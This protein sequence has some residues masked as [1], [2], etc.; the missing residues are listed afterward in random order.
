MC[1]HSVSELLL[2]CFDGDTDFFDIVTGVLLGDTF[3]PYLFIICPD[4][5]VRTFDRSNERK[6]LYTDDIA[7]LANTPT[8]VKSLLQ[9]LEEAAAS[10]DTINNQK[11]N[12]YSPYYVYFTGSS[13][14]V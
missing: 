3:C 13:D 6:W 4:Y 5:K 8:Q 11:I 12:R 9:S 7:L 14:G 10:M 1:L 2:S